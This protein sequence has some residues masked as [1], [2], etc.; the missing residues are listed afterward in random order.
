MASGV[1]ARRLLMEVDQPVVQPVD[2]E[3]LFHGGAGGR[4]KCRPAIGSLEQRDD[5]ALLDWYAKLQ[6]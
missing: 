2:V 4:G 6:R 1:L 5:P 3:A